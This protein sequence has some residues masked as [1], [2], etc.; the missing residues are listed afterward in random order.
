MGLHC[1]PRPELL[2]F[3]S[4]R[5]FS[6]F[7]LAAWQHFIYRFVVNMQELKK[8]MKQNYFLEFQIVQGETLLDLA[9]KFNP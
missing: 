5:L 1:L 9:W 2:M 7:K 8:D 3:H 4:F 6:C